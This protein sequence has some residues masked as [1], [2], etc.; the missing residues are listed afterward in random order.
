[1]RSYK[2]Y[3]S[4]QRPGRLIGVDVGSRCRYMFFTVVMD[5]F[6]NLEPHMCMAA[7]LLLKEQF[8]TSFEDTV[9][10]AGVG[11]VLSTKRKLHEAEI[12][13]AFG[14]YSELCST[15]TSKRRSV[16]LSQSTPV[17]SFRLED[18]A[19]F[20]VLGEYRDHRAIGLAATIPVPVD[21]ISSENPQA[22]CNND[23][24]QIG[25]SVSSH[26]KRAHGN[27][28]RKPLTT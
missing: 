27:S 21:G 12:T 28:A 3:E 24:Y 23:T 8:G 10:V 25:S 2:L 7:T 18:T 14:A 16:G 26:L 13:D 5:L 22:R 17:S 19:D 20:E 15:S 9:S 1:M 4:L 6:L 11:R